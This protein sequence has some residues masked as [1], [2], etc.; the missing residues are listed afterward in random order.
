MCAHK[1]ENEWENGQLFGGLRDQLRL[2]VSDAML[3]NPR[4]TLTPLTMVEDWIYRLQNQ[5]TRSENKIC[6]DAQ[7]AE[8]RISALV[9]K[10]S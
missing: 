3:T 1:D 2:A 6:S 4:L 7:V 5:L 10:N 8:Q 9:A